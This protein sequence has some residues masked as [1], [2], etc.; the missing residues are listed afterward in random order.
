M[1]IKDILEY[2]ESEYGVKATV[3]YVEPRGNP[4]NPFYTYAEIRIFP[5]SSELIRKIADDICGEIVGV[6]G[7]EGISLWLWSPYLSP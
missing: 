3:N 6:D 1:S 2:I 5:N 4:N 7:D